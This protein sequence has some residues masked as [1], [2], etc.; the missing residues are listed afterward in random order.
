MKDFS[1]TLRAQSQEKAFWGVARL[2]LNEPHVDPLFCRVV[3]A[4]SQEQKLTLSWGELL[5]LLPLL[6]QNQ[7]PLSYDAG[8]YLAE[9]T[10]LSRQEAKEFRRVISADWQLWQK[11]YLAH[12]PN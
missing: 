8:P 7:W 12:R 4:L 9:G 10:N 5:T 6:H 3:E 2:S 1:I 11:H